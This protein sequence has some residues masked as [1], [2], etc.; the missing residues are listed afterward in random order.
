MRRYETIMIADPDITDEN[1]DIAFERVQN[2][3]ASQEGFLVVLDK[4]GVRKLAYEIKKKDR[5]FYVRFDYCG[6][7]ALVNEI[8]RFFRID[9]RVLKY[10]TIVLEKDADVEKIK[11]EMTREAAEKEAAEKEAAEKEK[12]KKE[13]AEKE[14]AKKEAAEKEAAEKE[15]AKKENMEKAAL[16]VSES[17]EEKNIVDVKPGTDENLS[18]TDSESEEL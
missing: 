14:A 7:G 16:D 15:K 3:I 4:W 10:M 5:G 17:E 2:L 13:A 6:T 12:A 8:E 1:R 11:E 18:V 9:D